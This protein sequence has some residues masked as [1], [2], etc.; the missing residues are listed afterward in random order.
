MRI[1]FCISSLEVGGAETQLVALARVLASRG[2]CVGVAIFH[3]GGALE[4]PLLEAGI[5]IFEIGVRGRWSLPAMLPR[6]ARVV[7][8]F[9]PD[10]LHSYLAAANLLA[11]AT[12]PL[13]PQLTVVWGVRS[14]RR[15]F[16]SFRWFD[17]I[18]HEIEPALSRF[19]DGIIFNSDAALRAAADR[20]YRARLLVSIPNGT[21]CAALRPDSSARESLRARWGLPRDCVAIGMV[22]RLHP[23]KDHQTML[24]AALALRRRHRSVR[25]VFIG[26]GD[27]RYTTSLQALASELGIEDAIIWA[28]E[29]RNMRAAYNAL[30]IVTLTSRSEGFPNALA[31][32]MACGRPCV[33]TDVGDARRLLG[34]AGSVVPVGDVQALTDALTALVLQREKTRRALGLAARARV[35]RFFSLEALARASED[36]LR[37]AQHASRTDNCRG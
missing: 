37:S 5:E 7:R 21:D 35:E 11:V 2:H 36:A 13:F 18:T 4:M 16:R 23:V 17:R 30:D 28:G 15:D 8:R 34:P 9:Q 31:E 19:A 22:A 27:A 1:L 25:V 12:K 33:A 20:G 32:A 24:N 29:Q 10:V 14:T 6:M 26:G 3:R